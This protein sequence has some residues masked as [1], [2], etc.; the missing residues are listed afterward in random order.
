[1]M[2]LL[3]LLLCLILA[4]CA[5]PVPRQSLDNDFSRAG[6]FAVNFSDNLSKPYA[7]Q[8]G[9]SW[10]DSGSSLSLDL[11][12]PVGSILA[13]LQLTADQASIKYADGSVQTAVNADQLLKNVWGHAVPVS[14]L[15]Y[16]IQGVPDPHYM[17]A[18]Q[19]YDATGKLTGF[20][21]AGWQVQ[22]SDF[23]ENGPKKLRL[24]REQDQQRLSLRFVIN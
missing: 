14:G 12:N 15:R 11:L 17:A 1:M 23:D 18:K 3:G 16:W 8:G 13:Q 10:Y 22:M 20:Q 6:R 5:S 24:L 2:R 9:F 21:Q 19:T 7:A 4:A